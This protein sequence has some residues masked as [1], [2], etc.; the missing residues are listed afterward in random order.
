MRA[1]LT[2]LKHCAVPANLCANTFSE[3][4]MKHKIQKWLVRKRVKLSLFYNSCDD[5]KN[6]NF[7]VEIS[8][9]FILNKYFNIYLYPYI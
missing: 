8:Q 2:S 7:W 5:A 9:V 4:S 3:D 6:W 1:E